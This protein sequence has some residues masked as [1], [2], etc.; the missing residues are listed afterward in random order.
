MTVSGAVPV[1]P[2]GGADPSPAAESSR[3]PAAPPSTRYSRAWRKYPP[4][5]GF[6]P[7]LTSP[8]RGCPCAAAWAR[9]WWVRPVPITISQRVRPFPRRRGRAAGPGG[10][11]RCGRP[12]F[13][14]RRGGRRRPGDPA[15]LVPPKG[16]LPDG[17]PAE[18]PL[19]EGDVGFPGQ[20]LPEGPGKK[21]APPM[22]LAKKRTPVVLRSRR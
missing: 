12:A 2:R 14:S 11:S 7:Y 15:F 21:R 8:A 13:R 1:L 5:K 10:F 19:D 20:P 18:I 6:P 9:I 4:G 3:R 22:D 17:G 16:V